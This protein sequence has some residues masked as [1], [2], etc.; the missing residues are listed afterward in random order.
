VRGR[1][2]AGARARVCART[3]NKTPPPL[4]ILGPLFFIGAFEFCLGQKKEAHMDL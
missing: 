2:G 4:K 3:R 1:G